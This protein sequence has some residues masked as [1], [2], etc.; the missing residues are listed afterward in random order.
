MTHV[1]RTLVVLKPDSVGRSIVGE[2]ISRFERAGL[3]IVGM[4]MLRPDT[5]F[6]HHHYEG[7]GKVLSRHGQ[8]IFDITLKM[9]AI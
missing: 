5:E 2:V 6:L 1:Q 4:K 3:H 7:I 9:M 8:K